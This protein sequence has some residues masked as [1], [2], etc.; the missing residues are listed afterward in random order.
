MTAISNNALRI[1]I[2]R[3]SAIGDV[4]HA[5]SV[6]HNLRIKYPKAHISWLVSPPADMLLK[7]NPDIDELIIWD[8][9]PSDT[10]VAKFKILTALKFIRQ[11]KKLLKKYHFDIVLDIQGLFLTGLLAKFTD[12]PRR[13]GIHERHEGNFLFMTEMAPKPTSPH[14]I[15]HYLTALAPLGVKN[16]DFIAG[17]ILNL[18]PN[19][20]AIAAKFWRDNNIAL[21]PSQPL[22]MVNILTTWEDKNYPPDKFA[23]AL[24]ALPKNIQIVFCG[25]KSDNLAIAAAQKKMHRDSLSI[26]GKTSLIE[27]AMLLKTATL[28]LTSDTGPL[29]L[30]EA[31]GCKT[32]SLW[33]PT[34]PAI[35]GPLT[36]GHEFIISPHSCTACCKTRCRYK[37]NAC[38][39]AIA[40]KAIAAKLN[41]LLNIKNP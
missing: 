28:L 31:V 5:T 18:P 13:I 23:L 35:Y 30:A 26:A 24:D 9:R 20:G 2:I 17:L 3:L 33:G 15:K 41:A 34:H 38:M 22:L 39:N 8:R 16:S 19:F 6:V 10:A 14:K 36:S 4:L 21:N 7:N 11:A 40:P 1:L 37:T 12:A 32:L 25:T 29:Y 27:L